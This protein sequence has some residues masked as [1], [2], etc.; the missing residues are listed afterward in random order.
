MSDVGQPERKT[1]DR[2]VERFLLNRS[3]DQSDPGG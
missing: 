2:V 3:H 1:Q